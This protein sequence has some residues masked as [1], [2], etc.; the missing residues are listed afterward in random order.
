MKWKFSYVKVRTSVNP[1]CAVE[2]PE[3]IEAAVRGLTSER[4]DEEFD[5]P[6]L[7][8]DNGHI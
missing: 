7:G 5:D 1:F 3:V 8:K 2:Q 6:V 4:K